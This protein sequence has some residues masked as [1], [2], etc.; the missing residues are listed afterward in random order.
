VIQRRVWLL[1]IAVSFVVASG[2]HYLLF[3]EGLPTWATLSL[4][5]TLLMGAGTGILVGRDRWPDIQ[6][7]ILAWWERRPQPA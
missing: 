7:A 5:G 3:E 4:A 6:S 1:T 2:L